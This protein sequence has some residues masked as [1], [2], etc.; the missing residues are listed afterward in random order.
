M[1]TLKA[2]PTYLS[3]VMKQ[4]GCTEV[5]ILV[6]F[7]LQ[8][9]GTYRKGFSKPNGYCF[10]FEGIVI[11]RV[12]VFLFQVSTAFGRFNVTLRC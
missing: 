7:V 10:I 1:K 9:K 12:N 11:V 2:I 6:P 3:R 5:R 8:T 4:I